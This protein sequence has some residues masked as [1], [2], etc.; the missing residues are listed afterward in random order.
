MSS[1]NGKANADSTIMVFCLVLVDVMK[2]K[3]EQLNKIRVAATAT[4]IDEEAIKN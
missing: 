4:G 3:V 1:I 2:D